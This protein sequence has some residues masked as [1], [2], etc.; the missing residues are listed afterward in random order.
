MREKK[1]VGKT[2]YVTGD[3]NKR[4]RLVGQRLGLSQQALLDRYVGAG[5]AMDEQAQSTKP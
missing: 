2:F 5:L 4:L 1:F 3:E